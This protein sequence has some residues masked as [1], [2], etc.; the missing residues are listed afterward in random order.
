MPGPRFS[1]TENAPTPPTARRPCHR[2]HPFA[3]TRTQGG[4]ETRRLRKTTPRSLD[5]SASGAAPGPVLPLSRARRPGSCPVPASRRASPRAR[6]ALQNRG[7]AA[8]S[9]ASPCPGRQATGTRRQ[10]TGLGARHLGAPRL[11]QRLLLHRRKGD[12]SL[13]RLSVA[14]A[15][16]AHPTRRKASVRAN[17]RTTRPRMSDGPQTLGRAP[18]PGLSVKGLPSSSLKAHKTGFRCADCTRGPASSLSG[19][20]TARPV[21][22]PHGDPRS[23]GQGGTR[24]QVQTGRSGA[25][26]PLTGPGGA[27]GVAGAAPSSLSGRRARTLARLQQQRVGHEVFQLH[28][29]PTTPRLRRRPGSADSRRQGRGLRASLAGRRRPAGPHTGPGRGAPPRPPPPRPTPAPP[30]PG[31]P[32]PPPLLAPARDSSRDA[33]RGAGSAAAG[34]LRGHR[35]RAVAGALGPITH[36]LCAQLSPQDP[37]PRTPGV[38]ADPGPREGLTGTA[39]APGGDGYC[40]RRRRRRLLAPRPAPTNGFPEGGARAPLTR[41]LRRRL[42]RRSGHYSSQKAARAEDAARREGV[43]CWE[44]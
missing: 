41:S 16:Q 8:L 40:R 29:P 33:A 15:S 34:G 13:S 35:R 30:P 22:R 20:G 26:A 43:A 32:A 3:D 5:S 11:G 39:A 38:S 1:P 24:T 23:R 31:P 14:T 21:L 7:P 12:F 25:Q 36:V 44:L 37:A 10:G 17:L 9:P 2:E 6:K 18:R 4:A 28:G 27:A 42:R 19:Q